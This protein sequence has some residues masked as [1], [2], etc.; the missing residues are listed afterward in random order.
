MIFNQTKPNKFKLVSAACISFLIASCADNTTNQ[1]IAQAANNPALNAITNA[2]ALYCSPGSEHVQLDL[3]NIT[4]F[5]QPNIPLMYQGANN[6]EGPVWYDGALYYSNMG[7]HLADNNGFE[8]SNQTTIWRWV[9]GKKPHVWMKDTQA[10]TNGLALDSKGNLIA[11][12]QLDGSL[13]MIDW[14][15]Q[16]VTPIVSTYQ[17]KRFNSPNDLTIDHA[18]TVYFTDPNWNT[19]SNISVVDVQ[20]GGQAGSTDPG[21]RIYRATKN[22]AVNATKVTTLVPALRDKPNGIILSLDQQQLIVG[23]LQGLWVFDLD[24][25][26]VANPKQLLNTPIDGLGKDCSGNIYVTT[27]REI[28]ARKDGQVIVIL[29]K[30]H[31]EIGMLKVPGIH[32][33]TNVAFGGD[34]RRTLFVTGLTAPMDGDKLRQCGDQTCLKAGIYTTKLNVQGFPF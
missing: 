27:T 13:S 32:I 24:S 23:G 28:P 9:P 20:G 17:S 33:V 6:I 12:R 22:G 4:L 25:G 8:L 7:S 34:D 26:E 11:T 18:D 21:Q 31:K 2:N 15:T 16:Q 5:R 14:Q 19:P 29:D 10:G 3:T 30:Q 1:T